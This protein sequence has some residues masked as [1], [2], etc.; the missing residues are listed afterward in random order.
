LPAALMRAGIDRF[1]MSSSTPEKL[2]RPIPRPLSRQLLEAGL[3]IAALTALASLAPRDYRAFSLI[4]LLGLVALSLRLDRTALLAAAI[5]SA[6]AWDFFVIPPRF[7][8]TILDVD[9]MAM[10]GAYV[11]VA[12]VTSGLTARIRQQG[13]HLGAARERAGLL[14]EA[15]RLHRALFESVSHELKTPVTVLRTA[16][17]A[18]RQAATGPQA[19]LAEEICEATDRMDHVVGNLLDQARLES[20]MLVPLLDWCDARDLIAAAGAAVQRELGRHRLVV[21][22]AADMPLLRVD[23]PLLEQALGNLLLNAAMYAPAGT[24]IT[25]RAGIEGAGRRAFIAV[26]DEGPGLPEAIRAKPFQ[27]FRRGTA[28]NPGGLGLGLSIVQ[29]FVAAQGGTV[30]AGN[31]PE[32]GAR[33]TVFLPVIRPEAPPAEAGP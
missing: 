5:L 7:S 25:V 2:D 28:A 21:E 27:K 31:R 30:E 15:D 14:A 23:S 1:A 32:G 26:E 4:Y 20:G 24:A 17:L 11:V 3:V 13:E 22:V 10:F 18:L 6:V 12:L 29:G 9:D 16:G 33:F 19:A 8:F